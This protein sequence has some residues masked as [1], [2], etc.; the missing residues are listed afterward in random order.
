M[1]YRWKL[2][3]N[4]VT[5]DVHPVYKDD[6]AL[7]YEL[8]SGQRFFRAKLSSKVDFIGA[9]ADLIIN[10]GFTTE[11]VVVIECSTDY[12]LNW[13]T[14]HRAHFYKT[15]CTINLDNKKV[16]VQPQVLDQYNEILNAWD[17]E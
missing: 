3:I 1:I 4:S 5:T 15:D 12:G 8:E 10:A 2:T 13:S 6:L 14:F 16:T 7:N 9:D 17:K 11:F